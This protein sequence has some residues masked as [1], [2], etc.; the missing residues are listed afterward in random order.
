VLSIDV[1]LATGSIP[2]PAGCVVRGRLYALNAD[3]SVGVLDANVVTNKSNLAGRARV[4]VA[5]PP[6]GHGLGATLYFA[7][8]SVDVPSTSPEHS[9][10]S[11][12]VRFVSI[13]W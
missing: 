5:L 3:L 2:A 6:N 4:D 13:G 1:G 7:I 10:S 12:V 8:Q 9:T 11:D